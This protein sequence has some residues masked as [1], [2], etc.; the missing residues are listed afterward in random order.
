MRLETDFTLHEDQ[1]SILCN[2]I[3]L[4]PSPTTWIRMAADL[5]FNYVGMNISLLIPL[6]SSTL[7]QSNFHQSDREKC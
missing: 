7:W 1:K 6:R 4:D 5:Y 2:V 3:F